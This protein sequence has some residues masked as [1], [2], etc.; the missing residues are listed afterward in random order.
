IPIDSQ[1]IHGYFF[2]GRGGIG[3]HLGT[4][5]LDTLAE[6]IERELALQGIDV[7]CQKP[8]LVQTDK[9]HFQEWAETVENFTVFEQSEREE[10]ALTFVPTKDRIPNLIDSNANPDMAIVQI[11]HIS[12]ENPLDF[13]SYLHFKKN[14]KFF[15]YI[16]EG[17]KMLPRQKEKLQKRS[18]NT[19]LHINKEDFEKFK[20]HVAT[21]IIQDLIKAIKSSKEKK[22][23]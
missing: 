10:I 19:D 4:V 18:K 20:K 23:A 14:G 15:L 1:K 6:S 3:F 7:H 13:N 2:V 9:F 22:S 12:T 11:H 8:F 17:N 16:K 5:F 21:A